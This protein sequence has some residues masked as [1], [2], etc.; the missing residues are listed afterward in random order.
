MLETA[1][2]LLE[3]V[4][5]SKLTDAIQASGDYSPTQYGFRAVKFTEA[6]SRHYWLVA[7]LVM[8]E[9]R[10]VFNSARLCHMLK[11]LENRFHIPD[12]LLKILWDYL[13]DNAKWSLHRGWLR[14]LS[15]V[16]TFETPY[17]IVDIR[18]E[19]S[20][21]SY[22][23]GYADDVAPLVAAHKSEQ[24]QHTENGGVTS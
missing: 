1:G 10:H 24:S 23:A 18:F 11:T 20:N 21:E 12:Y 22:L 7:S 17:A 2:R 9:I 3:K 19:M 4:I 5:K 13:K 6:Y 8:L 15:L 16:R 14:D